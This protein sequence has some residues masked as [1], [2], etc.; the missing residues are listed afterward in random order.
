MKIFTTTIL[1]LFVAIT[2]VNAQVVFVN[3]PEELVGGYEFG[4][5]ANFGTPLT[6]TLVTADA[7]F[8][9]DGTGETATQGCSPAVNGMELEGK[10]ALVDRGGCTFVSKA[11]NAQNAGALGIIIFNNQPGAGVIALGGDDLS[12]TIPV[13]MLS[14]EDGQAIRSAL[15]SGAVNIT[16]GNLVLP[17]DIGAT[18][19]NVM[20]AP[21]GIVPLEQVTPENFTV[22]PGASIVNNGSNNAANFNIS[23]TVEYTEL[24]GSNPATVYTES[25]TL[26]ETVE[27]DSTSSLAVLPGFVPENGIGRYTVTYSVESDSVD[28]L[29]FDNTF[30]STF[31]ISDS[32]YSKAQWDPET[33]LPNSTGT[34]Y[35]LEGGGVYE[36]L[37][38][39]AF[40]SGAGL[41][42]I[43]TILYEVLSATGTTLAE[44]S[45]EGYVYEWVDADEDSLITNTEVEIVGIATFAF[46][47]D[48]AEQTGVL[49]LP[50]ANFETFAEPGPIV[51]PEASAYMVGV[52]HTGE[53]SV[54]MAFDESISYTQYVDYKVANGTYNIADEPYFVE[55]DFDPETNTPDFANL[56]LFAG[57]A[58]DAGVAIAIKTS[59]LPTS[60]EDVVGAETFEMDIFP[61]PTAEKLTTNLTFKQSTSFVEYNITAANGQVLLREL[62][63]SVGQRE[64]A[65][66][67]VE[68]LPAGQYFLMIRTEQGIQT[69]PFVKK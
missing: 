2:M 1:S 17:N 52:R 59:P 16:M 55:S 46:P 51:N 42:R 67:N 31:T 47:E 61:N 45:F 18:P 69:M 64:Q 57:L 14:Y 38:P 53:G 48:Y 9:D 36:L 23:A 6:D 27:P 50:V 44:A 5:A 11:L 34:F 58:R 3:S 63:N 19:A 56:G 4:T 32:L 37:A 33:G 39:F 10:I 7:A 12:I 62:D 20:T 22:V 41:I 68:A 49:R 40:P 8:I 13:A 25:T 43:D 65:E 24:D 15:E 35:A 30:S 54:F 66:F 26:E 21:Y 29:D 60:T 28:Q